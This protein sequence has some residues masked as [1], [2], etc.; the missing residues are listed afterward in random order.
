MKNFVHFCQKKWYSFIVD[1]IRFNKNKEYSFIVSVIRF[2]KKFSTALSCIR[3][4]LLERW[5]ILIE[6]Q[7]LFDK[8]NGT[9]FLCK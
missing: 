4:A 2:D 8:K 3:Y 1:E 5:Y 7:I 6:K 9:P